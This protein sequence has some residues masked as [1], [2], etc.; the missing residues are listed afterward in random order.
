MSLLKIEKFKHGILPRAVLTCRMRLMKLSLYLA[1]ACL[2]CSSYSL[3]A[4]LEP[5]LGVAFPLAQENESVIL[6]KSIALNKTEVLPAG[7]ILRTCFQPPPPDGKEVRRKESKERLESTFSRKPIDVSSLE[8]Q[9]TAYKEAVKSM[10]FSTVWTNP[11]LFRGYFH[12][13]AHDQYY[14]VYQK[15]G[16]TDPG[17]SRFF[18]PEGLFLA[19]GENGIEVL[20]VEQDSRAREAGFSAGDQILAFNG[21]ETGSDLQGFLARYVQTTQSGPGGNRFLKFK[22]TREDLSEPVERTISLPMSIHAD[23]FGP[24][25]E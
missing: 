22:V 2:Y 4:A 7:T 13:V 17:F 12:K 23:P 20:A 11:D 16:A 24:I 10:A 19:S 14:V 18:F 15:P 3:F 9:T 25:L 1:I 21:I 6:Q 8:N 5:S